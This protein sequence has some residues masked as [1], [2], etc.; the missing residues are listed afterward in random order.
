MVEQVNGELPSSNS[1]KIA[2]SVESI[3]KFSE[4]LG[5]SDIYQQILIEELLKILMKH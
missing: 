3:K 1:D 5:P 2:E 4:S